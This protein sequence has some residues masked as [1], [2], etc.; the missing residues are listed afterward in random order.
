MSADVDIFQRR[1][2][3]KKPGWRKALPWVLAAAVAAAL[4]G[5]LV[6]K[7]A[8]TGTSL[9]TPLSTVAADDRSKVPKTA[10]LEPEARRVAREF[11]QTA[12]ARKNLRAAYPLAGPMIRQGQT[13]K[14][15]MTGNIAV[16]PYPVDA[17]EFAPMKIDYSYPREAQIEVALLPRDNAKGVKSQLFIAVLVK[18]KQGKW[19]VNSWVPRSSA[20]IPSGSENNGGG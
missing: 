9:E 16:V 1:D 10:K 18:N 3:V 5:V 20:M 7:Y 4:I 6:W 12:V 19:Q 14:E 2:R 11:V 17:V 15:W 13:L 8:D